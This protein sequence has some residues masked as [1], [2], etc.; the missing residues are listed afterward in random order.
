MIFHSRATVHLANTKQHS[1][2][3]NVA[4]VNPDIISEVRKQFLF[5]TLASIHLQSPIKHFVYTQIFPRCNGC[6]SP[7]YTST[8][9][10]F[11]VHDVAIAIISVQCMTV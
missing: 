9:D 8:T 11:L 5:S 6:L 3:T 7:I 2:H 4:Q 1:P 10:P